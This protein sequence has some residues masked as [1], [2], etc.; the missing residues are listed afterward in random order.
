MWITR[1]DIE[2]NRQISSSVYDQVLNQYIEDAQFLDL[3]E[4]LGAELYNDII[5]NEANHTDLLDGSTYTYKGVSYTHVGLKRVLVYY[6]YARYIRFGSNT[7]T[8]FGV[9]EKQT[10]DSTNVNKND[11]QEVYKLNQQIGYKYFQN[12][13]A[14]LDRTNYPKWK[15]DYTPKSGNFRINKIC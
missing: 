2:A 4:L 12:V 5:A 6:S 7:D 15:N 1:S 11:R 14:F 10:P 3:Q 8:P 9:V 13:R